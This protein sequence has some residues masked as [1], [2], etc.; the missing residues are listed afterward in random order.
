VIIEN[1]NKKASSILIPEKA[2]TGKTIHLILEVTDN[3]R[4]ELAR[5]QRVILTIK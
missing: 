2:D 5:Y 3:G 4:P 1:A